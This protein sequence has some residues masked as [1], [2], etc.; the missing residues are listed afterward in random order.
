MRWGAKLREDEECTECEDRYGG[1][2]ARVGGAD[3]RSRKRRGW[4][5]G[6]IRSGLWAVRCSSSRV[7]G[8]RYSDGLQRQGMSVDQVFV[9]CQVL[10]RQA[11]FSKAREISVLPVLL[12]RFGV[13]KQKKQTG[14]EK[15]RSYG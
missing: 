9:V 7:V 6:M 13:K 10:R 5:A 3:F 8:F 15:T 12:L 1:V 14:S 4:A 11:R 2:L